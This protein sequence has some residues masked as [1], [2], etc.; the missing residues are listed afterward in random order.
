MVAATLPKPVMK[1][2]LSDMPTLNFYN[3]KEILPPIFYQTYAVPESYIVAIQSPSEF[4]E[5]VNLKRM[6]RYK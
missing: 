4:F 1:F 5:Q 3:G 6:L 2:G